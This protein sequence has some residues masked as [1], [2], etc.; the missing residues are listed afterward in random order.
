MFHKLFWCFYCWLVDF[1][2][3]NAG[4]CCKIALLKTRKF[5]LTSW[6][7]IH[8]RK[9]FEWVVQNITETVPFQINQ[10]T[11]GN[12]V[13][14]WYFTHCCLVMTK[15]QLE[16]ITMKFSWKKLLWIIQLSHAP[17]LYSLK[18]LGEQRFSF[19][20]FQVYEIRT[21]A[22]NRVKTLRKNWIFPL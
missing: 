20:C 19:W 8:T 11:P 9:S 16:E 15:Q 4:W 13:K 14:F 2:Q 6:Y 21:L 10:L 12:Q 22:R 1:D 18:I 5:F 3:G 17:N 7:E